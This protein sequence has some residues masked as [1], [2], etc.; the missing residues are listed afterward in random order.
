MDFKEWVEKK[1]WQSE[2]QKKGFLALVKDLRDGAPG[3]QL[4]ADATL[5]DIVA[6]LIQKDHE[7]NQ[8][9]DERVSN[10]AT[11]IEDKVT[12]LSLENRD[13]RGEVARLRSKVRNAGS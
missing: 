6:W 12:K 10:I 1:T 2:D 8:W 5:L 9:W 4:S 7:S 3:R 11:S 13:L